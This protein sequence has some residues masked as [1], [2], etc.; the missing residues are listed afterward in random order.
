MSKLVFTIVMI[1]C[2]LILLA[3]ALRDVVNSH[4]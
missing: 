4:F 2:V 1:G 3:W